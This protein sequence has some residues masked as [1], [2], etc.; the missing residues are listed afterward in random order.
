MNTLSLSWLESSVTWTI[1]SKIACSVNNRKNGYLCY[2]D[3]KSD[4]CGYS[5]EDSKTI[6]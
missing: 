2:R 5:V 1:E 3:R 6:V 4:F